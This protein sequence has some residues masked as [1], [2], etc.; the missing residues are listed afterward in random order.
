[1]KN[2]IADLTTG[3]IFERFSRGLPVKRIYENDKVLA[4]K[5]PK[6]IYRQHI[7]I[8]PKKA[9]KKLT[10]VSHKDMDYIKE[11]FI[12]ASKIV[13]DLDLEKSG[14]KIVMNRGKNQKVPQIHFHLISGGEKN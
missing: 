12:A 10:E 8:V 14:Y 1:M 11:I 9:I 3:I 5:H 6:P 7:L 13:N 2:K 4:F